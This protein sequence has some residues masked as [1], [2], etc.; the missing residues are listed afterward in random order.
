[1]KV[2]SLY[3]DTNTKDF[4]WRVRMMEEKRARREGVMRRHMWGAGREGT[5]MD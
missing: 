5:I 1:M 3:W 4:V 2:E